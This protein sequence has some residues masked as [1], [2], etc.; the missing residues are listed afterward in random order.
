MNTLDEEILDSLVAI[1]DKRDFL[2]N[3]LY[4][5]EEIKREGDE[6]RVL[7]HI[8]ANLYKNDKIAQEIVN[9]VRIEVQN[10]TEQLQK[11]LKSLNL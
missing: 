7:G 2:K 9:V 11:S 10:L 5:L 1:R 4:G 6:H 3:Y 8:L